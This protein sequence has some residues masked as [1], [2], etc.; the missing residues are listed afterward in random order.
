[1]T[2]VVRFTEQST[3]AV[4]AMGVLATG[5]GR[6]VTIGGVAAVLPISENHLAKVR[7]WLAR[8]GLVASPADHRSTRRTRAG[9]S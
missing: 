4:H 9:T 8:A 5:L 3:I 6:V 1:M 7:R 2:G